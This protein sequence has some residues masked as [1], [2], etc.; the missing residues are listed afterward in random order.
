M[1]AEVVGCRFHRGI[2]IAM[3]AR[4]RSLNSRNIRHSSRNIS[5]QPNFSRRRRAQFPA[6]DAGAK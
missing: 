4:T 1:L 3:R 2:R 5:R 6:P